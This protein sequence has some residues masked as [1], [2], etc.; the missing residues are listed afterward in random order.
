MN[1][2]RLM[3]KQLPESSRRGSVYLAVLGTA[4]IVSVLA[5]S[6]LALQRVQNRMLTSSADVRQAQ[7]NAEAAIELGLL[8]I[9]NDPNWRTT[10]R[11]RHLVLESQPER[12]NLLAD[13][14]RPRWQP[15]RRSVRLDRDDGRSAARTR[16]S[17]GSCGRSTS[18]AEPLGCLS[19][20]VAAGDAINLNG[21]AVLR[22]T[23][24]GLITANSSS[25]VELD[26]V[27]PGAGGDGERR[28]LRRHD[29]ANRRGRPSHHA[30]LV[31]R[32]R[33]LSNNGTE[34]PT[35]T[36]PRRRRIW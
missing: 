28:K 29:D 3:I 5:L 11:Q 22:A 30:Q 7:L 6:A 36:C 23:N 9:K 35:L 18:L 4:M 13:G 14:D 21:G 1:K 32:L 12:G 15:R 8:T 26:G 10:L 33:L 34:I 16:R 24:S 27:W 2:A 31:D 25:G 17:S 19:S 20:S